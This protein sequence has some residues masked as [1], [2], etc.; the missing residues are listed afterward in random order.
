MP[1]PSKKGATTNRAALSETGAR[2]TRAAEDPFLSLST[3]CR[4]TGKLLPKG[5]AATAARQP[6]ASYW[7]IHERVV[8]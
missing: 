1:S 8:S 4:R 3:G 2:A 7:I 6:F 5:E